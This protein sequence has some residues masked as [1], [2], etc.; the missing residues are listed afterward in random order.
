MPLTIE[1][2]W[3]ETVVRDERGATVA[4]QRVPPDPEALALR[5]RLRREGALTPEEE[6]AIAAAPPGTLETTDRRIASHGLRWRASARSAV[7]TVDPPPRRLWREVLLAEAERALAAGWDPSIHVDEAVRALRDTDRALNLLGERVASWASRDHPGLD[8]GDAARACR[9]L[10]GEEGGD[11]GTADPRTAPAPGLEKAR[12]ALAGAYR[13]LE[14]ARGAIEAAIRSGGAERTPNL[15]ALLGPEL[16]AQ[17]VSAAGGLERLSRLPASTVQVLGAEKAFFEHLRG[18]APPPRHGILFLHPRIQSAG[19]RARGR[20][21]R[22][23]AGTVAIAA[24]LDRAGRPVAPALADAFEARAR[25]VAAG[26]AREPRAAPPGRG[27]PRI[28]P[29]RPT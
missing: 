15:S 9:T 3:D 6:A 7:G 20:L 1:S 11:R 12:N 18:R 4:R 23:L 28:R 17:I 25:A 19:R 14:E 26:T 16:A 5:V 13:G 29:R 10:L 2:R 8:P 27:R 22:A 21:A 24:R